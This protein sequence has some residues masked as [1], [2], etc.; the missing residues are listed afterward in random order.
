MF[1]H[2]V[3]LAFKGLKNVF[4][5]MLSNTFLDFIS[6]MGVTDHRH[7]DRLFL[8]TIPWRYKKY[9]LHA[10]IDILFYIM[11]Y[12]TNTMKK[13]ILVYAMLVFMVQK[14]S[15]FELGPP[16]PLFVATPLRYIVIL[17]KS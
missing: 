6:D 11:F 10:S 3:G 4:L 8:Y 9:Y 5:N 2:F 17:I 15:R 1:D 7:Y 16:S 13:I 12:I 14:R